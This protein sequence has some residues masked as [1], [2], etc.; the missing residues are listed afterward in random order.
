MNKEIHS[1]QK[2]KAS[3]QIL[4]GTPPQV[5]IVPTQFRVNGK[6]V[7][8]GGRGA[9]GIAQPLDKIVQVAHLQDNFHTVVH[10]ELPRGKFD[11]FAKLAPSPAPDPNW[12]IALQ[13][14]IQKKFGV[15]GRFEKI[16]TEVLIL[17]QTNGEA[18][19]FKPSHRVSCGMAMDIN[20]GR[21]AFFSQPI[22]TLVHFLQKRFETPIVERTGLSGE[23]DFSL[24]WDEMDETSPNNAGLRRALHDQLGLGLMPRRELVEKL[25]IE[26]IK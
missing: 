22:E 8:D 14:E 2:P 6:L 5:E 13:R 19:G 12:T 25:V 11:F 24:K 21:C 15:V 26:P 9:M 18:R 16:E 7:C 1:W 4:Y 3:F 20:P 10:G 17:E 23:Y